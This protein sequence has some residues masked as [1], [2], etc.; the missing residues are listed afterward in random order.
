MG[1]QAPGQA[2]NQS[3][4]DPTGQDRRRDGNERS[5]NKPGVPGQNG[6]NP[7]QDENGNKKAGTMDEQQQA[8][9]QR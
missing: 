1:N 5:S 7:K 8:A 3:Q 9:M 6:Q 2:R 4:L